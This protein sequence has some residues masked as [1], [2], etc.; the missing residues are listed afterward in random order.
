MADSFFWFPLHSGD[1]L[2]KTATLTSQQIG[3]Y[4]LLLVYLTRNNRLPSKMQDLQM[5]CKMEKPPSIR[6]ALRLLEKDQHGY[7]SKELEEFK[8]KSIL[9]STKKSIAGK[10]GARA[11]WNG[12]DQMELKNIFNSK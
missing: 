7:F 1:F 9:N 8:V 4:I 10:K 12:K 6:A 11:R 2:S 5:I 3:C